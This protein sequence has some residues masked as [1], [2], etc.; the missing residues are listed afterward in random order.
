MLLIV[1]AAVVV[2]LPS[3]RNG[4]VWDDDTHLT[5][6]LVL[7]P[8]GLYYSWFTSYQPNYWPVTWT[9]FWLQWKLWGTNPAGYHAV[10]IA[11]HAVNC[12]LLYFVLLAMAVPGAV[13]AAVLFALHPVNV[14]CVAWVT[15]L[16]TLLSLLFGLMSL[17]LYLKSESQSHRRYYWASVL[18]FAA[19][20]LAKPAIVSLPVVMGLWAWCR[21]GTVSRRD[22][23]RLVPF[24]AVAAMMSFVEMWF[25]VNRSGAD[26]VVR[27]DTL[28]ARFAGAGCAAWFYFLKA[29]LPLN[30]CFV[31]PR[32]H[33]AGFNL[34]AWLP[35][36]TL[37]VAVPALWMLRG[38]L[39]RGPFFVLLAYC[40][41]LLPVMGFVNIFYMRYSLVA[42]HWQ[43]VALP[44]VVAGFAAL[45]TTIV[46][47]WG[48]NA[49]KAAGVLGAAVLM[50]CFVSDWHRQA[51]FRDIETLYRDTI[52]RNPKAVM[53]LTNLGSML[54]RNATS[55]QPPGDVSEA[56]KYLREATSLDPNDPEAHAVLGNILFDRGDFAGAMGHYT[57]G[58]AL[59]PG[60]ERYKLLGEIAETHARMGKPAEGAKAYAEAVRLHP[61]MRGL[62]RLGEL[63]LQAGDA[64]TAVESFLQLRANGV[65]SAQLSANL[66]AAYA[67]AGQ[68][69]EAEAELGAALREFPN[70]P[71]L[72]T[73]ASRL[74]AKP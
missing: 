17:L 68:R 11:L 21:T 32:W 67:A 56:E 19:G 53:A 38:R 42:D 48:T 55:S 22:V 10:N 63:S 46:S 34:I 24:L 69:Q 72:V 31:Y 8:H 43:Y 2:Y 44:V 30:L 13:V 18:L 70:A 20:M 60:P 62:V 49:R 65:Q 9:S 14:E 71:E 25:Q 7:Q 40:A 59:I 39:G 54:Y 1:M 35:S 3:L 66:V 36:I 12:V 33:L 73:A 61:D 5:A 45:L 27:V 50:L 15:Q 41:I 74:H 47:R 28:S 51:S 64:R 29:L 37:I 23:I 57:A 26:T 58:L 4:F 52:A 16:K 6:N